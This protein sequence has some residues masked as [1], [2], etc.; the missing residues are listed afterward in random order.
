MQVRSWAVLSCCVL[1]L[2]SGVLLGV[3]PDPKAEKSKADAARQMS[4]FRLPMGLKAEVFATDP[5][6]GSPV[7]IGLDEQNR[8]YVAEEYRFNRG[9][10]ENRTRPFLL[11]DD[12]QIK[13]L[14]D[15]LKMFEKFASKFEGGMEWFTKHPDQVRQL[16]DTDGDGRADRATIFAGGFNGVLDG[17][18]A[19]VMAK[20]GNIYFTCIPNLWLLKDADNDGVAE[21]RKPLLTGFG[22]N[23]GFLG[24]DLH[25]LCWGPDGKLYFSVGVRGFHV[26]TQE[27][28]TLSGPR[29][30]AVFRCYPDGSQLEVVHRGLRNPQEIAFDDYGNLFAAD[31]NCDKGDHSRLVY[32]VEGGESGWNMAYQTIPDPY[33]T[34]PWHAEKLWHLAHPGQPAYIVPPVGKLGAGPSGFC[35]Y[36]GTG[37][38]ERYNQ[39]FFMCNFTGNGGVEAIGVKPQGAGFEITE[40]TDFLKPLMATDAEFGYDGKMYVSD[41]VGL[42]W[43]GP[44]KG[45]RVYT[46]QDPEIIKTDVVQQVKKLF[47]EGFQQRPTD[48][49][50]KLLSHVDNRVRQRAQFA[51]AERGKEVVP[52]LLNI[53]KE[54]ASLFARLHAIWA[55]GQTRGEQPEIAT[56]LVPL[57]ADGESEVRAQVAKVLGQQRWKQGDQKL[58]ELL[59]D[60]VPRVRYFAAQTLGLNHYSPAFPAIVKMIRE[61][62]DADPYLRHAGIIALK[63]LDDRAQLWEL[64][65]D[66]SSAVRLVALLVLR[67]MQDPDISHFLKDADP[68]IVTEAA[69]AINDLPID[70][71]TPQLAAL[72]TNGDP[73]VASE[74]LLRRVLNAN[75]RLGE[76]D[77]AKAVARVVLNPQVIPAMRMEALQMLADWSEPSQRDRVNGF[78]RPL[79]KRD[80]A[81]VQTVLNEF[82][83]PILT[84]TNGALQIAAIQLITRLNIAI[85]DQEFFNWVGQKERDVTQ[86]VAALNL[87]VARKDSRV[88]QLLDVALRD[89]QPLLRAEARQITATKNP[90]L[91]FAVL[92]A[93]WKQ[94]SATVMEKQ[95]AVSQLATL[96]NISADRVLLRAIE[97]LQANKMPPELQ[98]DVIEAVRARGT[99]VLNDAL[100]KYEAQL[101]ASDPLARFRSAL[102]GGDAENGKRIFRSHATAQCFR[103]HKIQGQGGEAG[104]DLS[105]L[106]MRSPR[107][108]FLES[109]IDPNAKLTPGFGSVAY[110]LTDGRVVSGVLKAEDPKQVTVLTPEGKSVVIPVAEIEERT[111]AKSAM[112]PVGPILK[113][114]EIRDVIEYLATLR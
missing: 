26:K 96:K 64:R 94:D 29:A 89:A 102:V 82:A 6:L 83:M 44:T 109:M 71:E 81:I 47:Q 58:V 69:R 7:A 88:P 76:V 1:L 37:L 33:L 65:N 70:S 68:W 49:L 90:V 40:T 36:P 43:A 14:D 42:D 106:A 45:G 110:V 50:L 56:G 95:R 74:A 11:E 9:T 75:F 55:L 67:R 4:A 59:V 30:G 52:Q 100:N 85:D 98:V 73:A 104:P 108:H 114:G 57:L 93:A 2:G 101:P 31:N 99:P 18:A 20:D 51:L 92:E 72:L 97:D 77:H 107:E 80:P 22:V 24:H 113:L 62:E 53:A 61:N 27:G 23:A 111:A 79:S 35:Y 19:G 32:V 28:T 54:N 87:L 63:N 66:K 34:G 91:G 3:E 17:L 60:P 39:H 13:T 38:P 15:R 46:V 10:E 84:Q 86:R 5:Q 103:C 12:L 41:F 48:E 16:T 21:I 78:W 112:P 8:V 105:Q 25:G